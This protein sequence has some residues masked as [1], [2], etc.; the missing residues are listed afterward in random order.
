[1]LICGAAHAHSFGF[2][3]RMAA[4]ASAAREKRLMAELQRAMGSDENDDAFLFLRDVEDIGS[5]H[6][7]IPA[8]EL[9]EVDHSRIL[10]AQRVPDYF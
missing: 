8:K 9:W 5:W 6:I 3:T 4:S 10:F 1:M 2:P 7:R